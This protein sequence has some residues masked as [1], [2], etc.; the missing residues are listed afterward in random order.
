M[1]KERVQEKRGHEMDEKDGCYE[2][3]CEELAREFSMRPDNLSIPSQRQTKCKYLRLCGWYNA[4]T[5]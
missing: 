5:A 4:R 2:I 3:G 1:R